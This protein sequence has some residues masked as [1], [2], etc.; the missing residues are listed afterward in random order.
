MSLERDPKDWNPLALVLKSLALVVPWGVI[1]QA[2]SRQHPELGYIIGLWVGI[3]CMYVVPPRN[4][5]LWRYLLIGSVMT[6]V[7][8]LLR[9]I[10]SSVGRLR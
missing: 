3:V 9:V 1:E 7:H 2:L 8:P 6:V 4:L 5:S 10:F